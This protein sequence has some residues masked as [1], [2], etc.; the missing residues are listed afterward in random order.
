[1]PVF[2]PAKDTEHGDDV[3]IK[4]EDYKW[5]PSIHMTRWASRI[6]LEISGVRVERLNDISEQ[7]AE[8]EGI[9]IDIFNN[10]GPPKHGMFNC[11]GKYIPCFGEFD[12]CRYKFFQLWE[13]IN[14]AGS[15]DKNPFVWVIEFKR[16]QP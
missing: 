6:D 8:A 4:A 15:W 2:I 14:G 3:H 16:I 1:M 13:S 9:V 11:A 12:P 7:D 5:T 10:P